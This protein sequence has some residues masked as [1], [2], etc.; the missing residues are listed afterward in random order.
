MPNSPEPRVLFIHNFATHYTQRTF[1]LLAQRIDVQ[2]LFY[3]KGTEWYWQSEHGV[4][5][6]RFSARYLRGFSF[7]GTRVV[8]GLVRHLLAGPYDAVVKCING[9]FALPLSFLA[10]RLRG[11]PFVLWTGI[12]MRLQTPFH[13]FAYPMTRFLYRHSDAI[14]AYGSHVKSFLV[15][16][17]VPEHRIFVTRHAVDN[18]AYSRL[19]NAGEIA[20][21]KSRLQI[22]FKARIILYLGRLEP[23]KGLEYML[24]AFARVRRDDTVLVIAGAGSLRDE[25]QEL[26]VRLGI[27]NGVRFPGYVPV[28]K[29]IVYYAAAYVYVLPSV[30]RRS[31][32]ESWGL[33][34]NEA[35]NQGLPV[36]ASE[37]VGAAAGGL[38]RDGETGL[39]VPERDAASLARSLQVLLDSPELRDR[40]SSSAKALVKT[41]N[42]EQMVDQFQA[43][44]EFALR[45]RR[46]LRIAEAR[47]LNAFEK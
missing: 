7:F 26:A 20:S 13:R 35:F 28:E 43:A 31:G 40:L 18:S 30:T 36:I 14:V 6:G 15:S 12:W 25:L 22:S 24:E 33:V 34:V 21:L 46:R 27:A 5:E 23:I 1:E 4:L 41:W 9:R 19:I 37:A 45:T 17:G 32:K 29:A 10:A 39:V 44:I 47:R 8:P 16:E 38:V 3:S 2:F 11:K 42:Q